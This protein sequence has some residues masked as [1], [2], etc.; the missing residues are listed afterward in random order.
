MRRLRSSSSTGYFGK[1]K[2]RTFIKAW[3][4]K[5]DTK[6]SRENSALFRRMAF[7]YS[8]HPNVSV[9]SWQNMELLWV[10]SS[11]YITQERQ[12]KVYKHDNK[13]MVWFW[14]LEERERRWKEKGRENSPNSR[15]IRLVTSW[16]EKPMRGYQGNKDFEMCNRY[17]WLWGSPEANMSF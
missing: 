9:A 10:A 11:S 5:D 14:G 17:L 15:V 8:F 12:I 13:P 4:W 7:P 6:H 2:L 3:W 16:W 1:E